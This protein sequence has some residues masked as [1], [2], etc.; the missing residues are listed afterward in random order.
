MLYSYNHNVVHGH[1]AMVFEEREN[2]IF[3]IMK[4]YVEMYQAPTLDFS[5]RYRAKS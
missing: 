4:K 1:V 5:P 2:T 3:R